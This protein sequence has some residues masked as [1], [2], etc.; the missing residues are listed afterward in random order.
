MAR[1]KVIFWSEKNDMRHTSICI[2]LFYL[3][4]PKICNLANCFN[5]ANIFHIIMHVV[6]VHVFA[7]HIS[8]L[9]T[10]TNICAHHKRFSE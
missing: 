9:F 3:L 8:V 6:R 1:K 4:K 2:F 7:V 5:G 10:K